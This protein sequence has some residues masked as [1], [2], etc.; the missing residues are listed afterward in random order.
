LTAYH[1][2]WS[3]LLPGKTITPTFMEVPHCSG[4]VISIL[5]WVENEE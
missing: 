2:S 1:A 5:A 3:Q 4:G